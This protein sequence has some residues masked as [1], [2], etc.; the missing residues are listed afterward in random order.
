MM[1][2]AKVVEILKGVKYPGYTRDIVSF[3]MLKKV[4]VAGDRIL[5]TLKDLSGKEEIRKE[6]ESRIH[7]A[8]KEREVNVQWEIEGEKVKERTSPFLRKHIENVK[9]VI[10]VASGKGGVGK[11]TV[12]VNLAGGFSSQGLRTGILD[13]DIYGPNIPTLLHIHERPVSP[14]GVKIFPV[15]KSGIQVMSIGFFLNEND[16]VIWRGPLVMRAIQQFLDDVLWD[17]LDVLV[18]DLPPGTGDV[19]LTLVQNVEIDGAIIVTVP[20]KMAVDDAR[21]ALTMFLKVNVPVLG[22]VENM[23]FFKC[24]RCGNEEKIFESEDYNR[25]LKESRLPLLARIPIDKTL[26]SESKELPLFSSERGEVSIIFKKLAET[27][28]EKLRL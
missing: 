7:L 12:S 6:I 24:P 25:F 28:R 14:D 5:I 23:S 10:A 13:A 16:A 19:Q 9:R 3:G 8:L 1:T 21:R 27:L 15:E 2:E 17:N 18:I 11:S 26:S 4:E 22:I 20:E